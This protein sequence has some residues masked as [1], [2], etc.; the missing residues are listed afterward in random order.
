MTKVCIISIILYRNLDWKLGF[1]FE[2]NEYR[3]L[4][5]I[6]IQSERDISMGIFSHKLGALGLAMLE[7]FVESKLGEKF[8]TE[9]RR[10]TDRR[11]AIEK[12]MRETAE[13]LWKKWE[14]KRTWN[15]IFNHL[16]N[17]RELLPVL[18]EAIQIY[19]QHPTD[20]RFQE[21]LIEILHEN[22]QLSQGAINHAVADFFSVLT[23]ELS[24]VDKNFKEDVGGLSV[25]RTADNVQKIYQMMLERAKKDVSVDLQP[26]MVEYCEEVLKEYKTYWERFVKKTLDG[27]QDI[28]S[29]HPVGQ[30]FVLS[31]ATNQFY[32]P[33]LDAQTDPNQKEQRKRSSTST[34]PQSVFTSIMGVFNTVVMEQKRNLA[35]L[36]AEPGAGKTFSLRYLEAE[37]VKQY[38]NK[39]S[40]VPVYIPLRLFSEKDDFFGYIQ[41]CLLTSGSG[42]AILAANLEEII[43]TGH[44]V[45]IFDGLNEIAKPEM[46]K[47]VFESIISLSKKHNTFCLVS[48]RG[49]A[50]NLTFNTP[51]ISI[52]PLDNAGVVECINLYSPGYLSEI[53]QLLDDNPK[54][55]LL[56]LNPYRLKIICEL[57]IS[58][59]QLGE[60]RNHGLLPENAG[61]LL[62]KYIQTL[63]ERWSKDVSSQL[64]HIR[65]RDGWQIVLGRLASENTTAILLD[66]FSLSYGDKE[67]LRYAEAIGVIQWINH[68]VIFIHQQLQEYFTAIWLKTEIE[69]KGEIRIVVNQLSLAT[70]DEP[71][72]LLVGIIG[73]V[74]INQ[75]IYQIAL[76]DPF[77]AARCI[78]ISHSN[79][80]PKLL[81]WFGNYLFEGLKFA[82][83]QEDD[84]LL[85]KT[86]IA[87][88]DTEY[89]KYCKYL[90]KPEV[91]ELLFSSYHSRNEIPDLFYQTIARFDTPASAE[92][93]INRLNQLL[94]RFSERYWQRPNYEIFTLALGRMKTPIARQF[95]SDHLQDIRIF[96]DVVKAIGSAGLQEAEQLREVLEATACINIDEGRDYFKLVMQAIGRSGLT[97]LIPVL[98]LFSY[99]AEAIE[100]LLKFDTGQEIIDDYVNEQESYLALLNNS[101]DFI[102]WADLEWAG[103][104][105]LQIWNRL[106]K[107]FG[108]SAT[109]LYVDLLINCIENST[110]EQEII[111]AV[112]GL[113][114]LRITRAIPM[115]KKLI[116]RE[117][118]LKKDQYHTDKY[119]L[120]RIEVIKNTIKLSIEFLEEPGAWGIYQDN[121]ASFMVRSRRYWTKFRG[122]TIPEDAASLIGKAREAPDY[123]IEL[124]I[125][126]L[127]RKDLNEN[128]QTKIY[129]DQA[130]RLL[131]DVDY[132]NLASLLMQRLM[133]AYTQVKDPDHISNAWMT[134][135]SLGR[136][137]SKGKTQRQEVNSQLLQLVHGTDINLQIIGVEAL[138]DLTASEQCADLF[139][140]LNDRTWI[141]AYSIVGN[142]KRLQ[143]DRMA[144]EELVDRLSA[145][146]Q[147]VRY[148]AALALGELEQ[149]EFAPALIKLANDPSIH[150]RRAMLCALG[151]CGSKDS[152]VMRVVTKALKAENGWERLEAARVAGELGLLEL[153]PFLSEKLQDSDLRVV[154]QAVIA[155]GKLKATSSLPGLYLLFQKLTSNQIDYWYGNTRIRPEPLLLEKI[156]IAIAQLSNDGSQYNTCLPWSLMAQKEDLVQ[157]TSVP[158]KD[159]T[160]LKHK[161]LEGLKKHDL[162]QSIIAGQIEKGSYVPLWEGRREPIQPKLPKIPRRGETLSEKSNIELNHIR[163]DSLDPVVRYEAFS[164][165]AENIP[166]NDLYKDYSNLDPSLS[167][168]FELHRLRLKADPNNPWG[169]LTGLLHINL[170]LANMLKDDLPGLVDRII[171]N[172]F[173]PYNLSQNDS[174]L[175]L[176][177]SFPQD[178]EVSKLANILLKQVESGIRDRSV[179]VA[180]TSLSE[181]DQLHRVTRILYKSNKWASRDWWTETVD[182]MIN[183]RAWEIVPE[184]VN[185]LDNGEYGDRYQDP[186]GLLCRMGVYQV[187]QKIEDSSEKK[188]PLITECMVRVELEGKTQDLISPQYIEHS[189]DYD[190]GPD[191]S[192]WYIIANL[193]CETEA[194]T[195]PLEWLNTLAKFMNNIYHDED[196]LGRGL[197]KWGKAGSIALFAE[198]TKISTSKNLEEL[199][200]LLIT[201]T[202][203][204]EIHNSLLLAERESILQTFVD[205]RDSEIIK[206]IDAPDWGVR[207]LGVCLLIGRKSS[208][209]RVWAEKIILDKHPSV[210]KTM[211]KFGFSSDFPELFS[212]LNQ[213]QMIIKQAIKNQLKTQDVETRIDLVVFLGSPIY[214]DFAAEIVGLLNDSD[215]SLIVAAIDTL[216][217]MGAIEYKKEI[218]QKRNSNDDDILRAA[219]EAALVWEDPLA[220][221]EAIGYLRHKNGSV[222]KAAVAI[223]GFQGIQDSIPLIKE[224]IAKSEIEYS[225][226]GVELYSE[227]ES[228]L[229]ESEVAQNLNPNLIQND[230]PPMLGEEPNPE[231]EVTSFLFNLGKGISYNGDDYSMGEGLALLLISEIITT[232]YTQEGN[233]NYSNL[234]YPLELRDKF[235]FRLIAKIMKED[236]E[237]SAWATPEMIQGALELLSIFE[238]SGLQK[239]PLVS[240]LGKPIDENAITEWQQ[241]IEKVRGNLYAF[242]KTRMKELDIDQYLVDNLGLLKQLTLNAVSSQNWTDEAIKAFLYII[243]AYVTKEDKEINGLF[244]L[245]S[246]VEMT[247][248][249]KEF[250][251]GL[252]YYLGK[253]DFKDILGSFF[254]MGE[255][256]VLKFIGSEFM[257]SAQSAARL[258]FILYNLNQFESISLDWL[259]YANRWSQIDPNWLMKYQEERR[260]ID[261]YYVFSSENG[262][263][264]TKSEPSKK[265]NPFSDILE[266]ATPIEEYS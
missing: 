192:N 40:L 93:I 87:F 208:L 112:M 99:R 54:V 235:Q 251:W 150:V 14:D 23:D 153:I 12:A 173:N 68:Q 39:D 244:P 202:N 143:P 256:R 2:K 11:I 220:P 53:I 221:T 18:K 228:K 114:F 134:V 82:D 155:L 119:Y 165:Y 169:N 50:E 241:I 258:S 141:L 43:A 51:V 135:E 264:Q 223:C 29:N 60:T 246:Q 86:L 137:A 239:K 263:I 20:T 26:I 81:D 129:L 254:G 249:Q 140:Y 15:A 170:V 145:R 172:D 210:L 181:Y 130:T 205:S 113:T 31:E 97:E 21:V 206:L 33:S 22:T 35:V 180:A 257:L 215:S 265:I 27:V 168:Q 182:A 109:K 142:M 96:S 183:R 7:N 212:T 65:K 160:K 247:K 197:R 56:A 237:K 204:R 255:D 242:I 222:V 167:I 117:P 24:L 159:K 259:R 174:I 157:P 146:A 126:T 72:F 132:P 190:D 9:L 250:I 253:E 131:I 44:A 4:Q 154:E 194:K 62:E 84:L 58:D 139:N 78:G 238:I 185:K 124:A 100:T 10:D 195:P 67:C 203:R 189:V 3:F 85:Q 80:A 231:T 76:I 89:E 118:F 32:A 151:R 186:I 77:L 38:I 16:P 213:N 101:K 55:R 79:L 105:S 41:A 207:L 176:A 120:D 28:Q 19:A 211:L 127:C 36:I 110:D 5:K 1:H 63:E 102:P 83:S 71:I 48:T 261:R 73:E 133:R 91:R 45:F 171:S 147:D 262:L 166:A 57:Y 191:P 225:Q 136:Y 46:Q 227:D 106:N 88:G 199:C 95:L 162:L 248:K 200:W 230:T 122:E 104:K 66:E 245:I 217:N 47:T 164:R 34:L 6:L 121:R 30:T 226:P 219:L 229:P 214:H 115:L 148:F 243:F 116:T 216:R 188:L 37:L 49:L 161:V 108:E 266:T 218:R 156:A 138:A 70:W 13:R 158:E 61:K 234:F 252:I 128:F 25:L 17:N 107:T 193:A 144:C 149:S 8:V 75:L 178:Y 92:F 74:Y 42:H 209:I 90:F 179:M 232:T 236:L 123:G 233:V 59:S 125:A 94:P 163:K 111:N 224:F 52:R 69:R 103:N 201:D 198:M 64:T 152:G 177:R 187:S 196:W 175:L 98:K 260:S 184:L 240:F